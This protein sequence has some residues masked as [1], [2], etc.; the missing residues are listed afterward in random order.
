MA[1]F[2]STAKLKNHLLK[3]HAGVQ[4][5]YIC[6]LCDMKF[7]RKAKLR[8][9]M[10]SHTGN[11]K[12]RCGMCEKGFLQLGHLTRHEKTHAERK[13]DRC[14]D[15]FTKWSLL[16]A[17]KRVVHADTDDNKCGVCDKVFRTR[18]NLK[19]HSQVH[20]EDGDRIVYQCSA[21]DCPK[22]FYKRNSMMAH[23]KSTHENQKFACMVDGCGRQ[24]STK[25]KLNHHVQVMH[26]DGGDNG[27]TKVKTKSK[28]NKAK[29]KDKGIQK[30][31][32]ASKL[33]NIVL[34]TEFERTI[35]EGNG[36]QITFH[37]DQTTVGNDNTNDPSRSLFDSHY[38]MEESKE[39]GNQITFSF[40][41]TTDDDQP[42]DLNKALSCAES[43]K[44]DGHYNKKDHDAI[45]CCN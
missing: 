25:Q 31:S 11:Y 34:P 3:V 16:L 6:D 20:E 13:C 33:F 30:V 37:Y 35:I 36:S 24:L 18:R 40:E 17:H 38:I 21:D 12:Y 8:L 28:A 15:V 23:Y 43:L 9:H 2:D 7:V 29:R 19:H 39:N 10:F 4:R 5:E 45:E 32:T 14:D 22:F 42:D 26:T 27:R 1:Y 44:A 41:Q